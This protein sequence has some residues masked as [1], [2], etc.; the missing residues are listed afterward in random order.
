MFKSIAKILDVTLKSVYNYK[1]ENRP[2]VTLF[3]KYF[4]QNDLEEF[5]ST[6][7]ISKYEGIKQGTQDLILSEVQ[8]N[9]KMLSEL[10]EFHMKIYRAT[11][12]KGLNKRDIQFIIENK[13]L[14]FNLVEIK[15]I[16]ERKEK[17]NPT[18]TNRGDRDIIKKLKEIKEILK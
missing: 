7:K 16:L 11:I 17:G 9:S 18:N 13:K 14:I 2:V 10:L 1:K 6:G 4:T 15:E 5:L 12:F 3:E 8:N